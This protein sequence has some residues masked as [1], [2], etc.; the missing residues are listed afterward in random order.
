MSALSVDRR[1]SILT[2]RVSELLALYAGSGVPVA[3][4]LCDQHDPT[5]VAFTVV[6]P[7]VAPRQLTY[8][9][10][11]E[12]SQRFAAALHALGVEEG[13]RVATLMGK[14]VEQVIAAVAIWRLGAVHLPLFTAFAPPAIAMRVAAAG[15]AVVVTD[16]VQRAK[17]AALP[18]DVRALVQVVVVGTP[19]EGE[20]S[21]DALVS[22]HSPGLAP[23]RLAGDAPLVQIFTSGTTGVPKA[24]VMPVRA[25]AAVR[26]YM[27]AG[28]DVRPGDVYWNAADPGWAYGHY[29]SLLGPLALGVPS[30]WLSAGFDAAL[31]WRILRDL[32][33]SNFAAAPT[34]YR[35][36]RQ[37]VG[38][39]ESIALRCA[40]AAGEP[41]TAEVNAWAP[42]ALGT[43]VR[44]HYGQ[45]ETGMVVNNHQHSSLRPADN[46]P[47]FGV[48]MPGWHTTVLAE[49]AI[50]ALA[51]GRPGRLAV[52]IG[53]SPLFWFAGYDGD[54]E[55]SAEKFT[56]DGRWYLTGDTAAIAPDG[57]HH[58]VGRD[59]DVILMAGYRIGPGDVEGVL[60]SH[61]AVAE[62]AVVAAPDELRGEVLEA[63]V[64]P[65]QGAVGSEELTHELQQLVKTDFAAHAFPRRVHY[66]DDLPKTPS[67]KIQRFVLRQQLRPDG[68]P[69]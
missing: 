25:L 37:H 21:F 58:F 49:G 46:V 61:P 47:G 65:T 64:V 16:Q 40:S 17:V 19:G 26:M 7:D 44:D 11:R 53:S 50:E 52:D 33:V 39:G 60:M 69:A 32:R 51:P 63:F 3:D 66:L 29:Y 30:I 22:Q 56:S 14:S 35:A 2:G 43:V 38:N 59:D 5:T 48:D 55:R 10:L 36:L 15:A 6:G 57:T 62:A 12:M 27:E 67:G 23:V 24:V 45:T 4:L 68:V 42:G 13:T 20:L 18:A 8:G 28:L 34:V 54:D 1:A 41:L 31:T 9:E